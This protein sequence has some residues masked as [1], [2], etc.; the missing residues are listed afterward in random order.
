MLEKY[1]MTLIGV[2]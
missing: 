1:Q 2:V